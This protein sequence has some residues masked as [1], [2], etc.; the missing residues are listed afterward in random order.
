MRSRA[1]ITRVAIATFLLVMLAFSFLWVRGL[2]A[3]DSAIV[4]IFGREIVAISYP[5]HLFLSLQDLAVD[6][7]KFQTLPAIPTRLDYLDLRVE[8]TSTSWALWLPH[9][10]PILFLSAVPLWQLG[11]SLR[12]RRRISQHA[13]VHCGYDLRASTDRCPECGAHIDG[14]PSGPT[15]AMLV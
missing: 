9:W 11:T 2:F 4:H 8:R 5:H 7:P 10:I 14:R 15:S 6:Q 1:T 13:C 12:I 3:K